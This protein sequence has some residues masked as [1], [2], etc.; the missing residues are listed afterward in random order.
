MCNISMRKTRPCRLSGFSLHGHRNKAGSSCAGVCMR[1]QPKVGCALTPS[2][3][4]W[5]TSG[6][7]KYQENCAKARRCHEDSVT[8]L[9]LLKIWNSAW[10]LASKRWCLHEDP[11]L[12]LSP[13]Y[14]IALIPSSNESILSRNPLRAVRYIAANQLTCSRFFVIVT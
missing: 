10:A 2:D 14:Y 3:D 11:A 9:A 5:K 1:I 12:F 7:G 4:W 13:V 6:K 8:A